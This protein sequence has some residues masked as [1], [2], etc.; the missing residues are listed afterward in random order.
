MST[1]KPDRRNPRLADMARS[2]VVIAVILLGFALVGR[3]FSSEPGRGERAVDY[4]KPL[5]QAAPVSD[6]PL[7]APTELPAGWIATSVT[8]DPGPSGRWHIG[9]LTA[10]DEYVGL[11]Q[12]P[13]PIDATIEAFS[14]DT[15]PA[16]TAQAAGLGW[17]L[18][19]N[20]DEETTFIRREDDVT[21]LVTGTAP[22][23]DIET[24][25]ETLEEN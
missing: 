7:L 11:E 24:F 17:E 15:E 3:F 1:S 4:K 8:Y 13:E 14:P 2:I 5:S 16:G 9:V 23:D 12:T 10:D 25:M 19:T 6:F 21:V 18:R 20:G 22:R